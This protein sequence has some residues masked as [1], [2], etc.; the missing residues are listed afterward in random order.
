[1][2]ALAAASRQRS[3]TWS[4]SPARHNK[5]KYDNTL[6]I[7]NLSESQGRGTDSLAGSVWQDKGKWF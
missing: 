3:P 4:L 7:N 2:G 6:H 1:M 5:Q